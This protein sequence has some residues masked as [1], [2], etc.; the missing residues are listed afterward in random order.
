MSKLYLSIL[1]FFVISFKKLPDVLNDHNMALYF[2][3]KLYWFHKRFK[4]ANCEIFP[5]DGDVEPIESKLH[6]V[7]SRWRDLGLVLAER[8]RKLQFTADLERFGYDLKQIDEVWLKEMLNYAC[9]IWFN[10]NWF[11]NSLAHTLLIY[12]YK[13]SLY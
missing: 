13:F 6:E 4:S 11:K 12:Y 3:I 1:N 9:S 2:I 10:I 8:K 7:N 5:G